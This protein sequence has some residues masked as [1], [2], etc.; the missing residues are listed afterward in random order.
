MTRHAQSACAHRRRGFTLIELL[1]VMAI[2]ALLAAMLLPAVQRVRESARRTQ[3]INNL[4]QIVVAMHNYEGTYKVFPPGLVVWP[5]PIPAR[6]T[7]QL[8]EAAQLDLANR[9]VLQLTSWTLTPDWSWHSAIVSYMD[10]MTINFDYRV[11]KYFDAGTTALATP[12]SIN[13]QYLANKIPS[14]VCPSASLPTSTPYGMGYGTYRG[15]MGT[16][17]SLING[18]VTPL[19][20]GTFNGML[21]P[22]SAVAMRDVVDGTTSTL[23]VG[24]SPYGFWADGYSCCVRVRNDLNTQTNV[25]RELFDDY[26]LDTDSSGNWT[27][28]QF[29]SYGST[30]GDVVGVGFVDGGAKTISKRIDSSVFMA[31]STRNGR[32]NIT[33]TSF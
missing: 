10:Q 27:G 13:Q 15:C 20:P 5:D 14:Y 21:Y 6:V 2:I 30:H 3:C 26:W 8:P 1:V 9:Q 29:F 22:N 19:V 11:A 28:L 17:V 12:G 16:N 33:D 24:D 25:N 32:E 7:L 23:L 4:K 18:Q 31:L